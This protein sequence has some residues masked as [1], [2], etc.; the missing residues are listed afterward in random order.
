MQG[1]LKNVYS[2]VAKAL[3]LKLCDDVLYCVSIG[4]R[5][6]RIFR[7]SGPAQRLDVEN[8]EMCGDSTRRSIKSLPHVT[9][10]QY[11]QS[12][13]DMYTDGTTSPNSR[14]RSRYRILVVHMHSADGLLSHWMGTFLFLSYQSSTSRGRMWVA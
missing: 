9:L 7:S 11:L 4:R 2:T 3:S 13:G 10:L 12:L 6:A 8:V 1:L 14:F 5:L